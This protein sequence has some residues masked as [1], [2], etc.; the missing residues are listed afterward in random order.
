MRSHA[1]SGGER[2]TKVL[3]AVASAA[4]AGRRPIDLRRDLVV[5]TRCTSI[6]VGWIMKPWAG[7]R[8]VLVLVRVCSVFF[9]CKTGE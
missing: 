8:G 4:R 5:R 6:C 9:V 1:E 3:G 2:K 7:R